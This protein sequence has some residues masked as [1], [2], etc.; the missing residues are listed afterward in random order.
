MHIFIAGLVLNMNILVPNIYRCGKKDLS[1]KFRHKPFASRYAQFKVRKMNNQLSILNRT[2]KIKE[3]FR[4]DKN[5]CSGKIAQSHRLQKNGKLSFIE[6]NYKGN[7]AIFT[8]TSCELD[9][10]GQHTDLI[11]IGKSKASTF[12]GFCS[13]HDKSIFKP[14][15]DLDFNSKSKEQLFLHSYRAFA[16]SYHIQRQMLKAYQTDSEFTQDMD[17][18]CRREFIDGYEI[19]VNEGNNMKEYLNNNL[20][21][22]NFDSLSYFFNVLDGIYPIASSGTISPR[23][24]I[25]GV[26][27]NNHID[28]RIPYSDIM[29]TLFP[30]NSGTLAIIAVKNDDNKGL[31]LLNELTKITQ[32]QLVLVLS[33][34]LTFYA[35][36]TFFSP[37]IWIKM[38]SNER[39]QYLRELDYAVSDAFQMTHSFQ[40]ARTNFFQKKFMI[41]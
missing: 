12:S 17:I 30:Y 5:I 37:S 31:I 23:F 18:I 29:F 35:E 21:F 9:I 22:K 2:S 39:K 13:L 6:E 28:S 14:I 20:S 1:L 40:L 15:E 3:C 26:P 34:F 11:P 24:S 36:N 25:Y 10:N 16:H 7:N 19:G 27:I 8:P 4:K 33:T 41:N 38:S 32:E